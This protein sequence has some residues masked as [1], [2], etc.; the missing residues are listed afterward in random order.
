MFVENNTNT[1]DEVKEK[2]WGERKKDTEEFLNNLGSY[3]KKF[4]DNLDMIAQEILYPF[5][6][7]LSDRI[8]NIGKKTKAAI[9]WDFENFALPKNKIS[10]EIFLK[11]IQPS[12][13]YYNVLTKNV[14]GIESH[15][16]PH[17]SILKEA[18]FKII[19]TISAEKQATDKKLKKSCLRFC[20][21]HPEGL[22][23]ILISGDGGYIEMIKEIVSKGHEVRL[24]HSNKKNISQKM[25]K[26][27]PIILDINTLIEKRK[28]QLSKNL[29]KEERED[30]WFKYWEEMISYEK[31]IEQQIEIL[32]TIGQKGASIK[33]RSLAQQK[34]IELHDKLKQ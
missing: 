8:L 21:E 16:N 2:G 12:K 31:T 7:N 30:L 5:E 22:V 1:S 20:S 15:I 23:I 9:F 29:C 3:L 26:L 17:L 10:A 6:K 19:R 18:D 11:L 34:L 27:V 24:I 25:K 33:V 13:R 32:K 4:V 28:K 14:Y